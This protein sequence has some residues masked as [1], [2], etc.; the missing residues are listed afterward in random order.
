MSGVSR[1]LR[2]HRYRAQQASSEGQ[3]RPHV[4]LCKTSSSTSAHES[5][6]APAASRAA[7]RQPSSDRHGVRQPCAA[8]SPRAPSYVSHA[9][10]PSTQHAVL[11]SRL[12]RPVAA[13]SEA[14]SEAQ[15]R[16]RDRRLDGRL[17]GRCIDD[18]QRAGLP[19]R[20]F[21]SSAR[22]GR[23]QPFRQQLL[24]CCSSRLRILGEICCDALAELQP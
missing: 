10:R 9:P 2:Y 17:S 19:S 18:R 12:A 8:K 14:R 20:Y 21:L 1:F 16:R 11:A 13:R 3:R 22:C 6:C 4:Q 7:Q 5:S 23:L 15:N 24:D